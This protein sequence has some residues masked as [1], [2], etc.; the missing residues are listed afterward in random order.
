MGVILKT[1]LLSEVSLSTHPNNTVQAVATST[2]RW[3]AMDGFSKEW[4][5]NALQTLQQRSWTIS[6]Y[7]FLP[8]LSSVLPNIRLFHLHLGRFVFLNN[9][10]LHA[11]CYN[12]VLVDLISTNMHFFNIKQISIS[13]PWTFFKWTY[14]LFSWLFNMI[15]LDCPVSFPSYHWLWIRP[16]PLFFISFEALHLIFYFKF[17]LPY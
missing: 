17:K 1:E 4:T 9:L 8:V 2:S 10:V 3:D 13:W 14:I 11:T 12:I 16:P 15:P 5:N 7:L 6:S